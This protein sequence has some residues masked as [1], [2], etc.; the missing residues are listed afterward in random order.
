MCWHVQKGLQRVQAVQHILSSNLPEISSDISSTQEHRPPNDGQW[1]VSLMACQSCSVAH[2]P[3]PSASACFAPHLLFVLL[4]LP[5]L[6]SQLSWQLHCCTAE[7]L[8]AACSHTLLLAI[9]SL[10]NGDQSNCKHN[11]FPATLLPCSHASNLLTCSHSA[12]H[13]NSC[14]THHSH[15]LLHPWAKNM[16]VVAKSMMM[17]AGGGHVCKQC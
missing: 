11:R 13:H 2:F 8:C 1:C 12:S 7:Q 4:S 16:H 17:M 9:I 6:A 5:H 10:V 14:G 3:L 15:K